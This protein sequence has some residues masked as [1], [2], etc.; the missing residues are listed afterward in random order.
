MKVTRTEAS[1]D[2]C[3][4]KHCIEGINGRRRLNDTMKIKKRCRGRVHLVC[5]VI[6]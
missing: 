2:I 3:G 6:L 4:M 1:I 5:H